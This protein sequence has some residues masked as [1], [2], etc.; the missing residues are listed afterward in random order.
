MT[1][2]TP[3]VLVFSLLTTLTFATAMV[4]F[5]NGYGEK[6]VLS[7]G[8]KYY[9]FHKPNLDSFGPSSRYSKSSTCRI[10]RGKPGNPGATELTVIK[11]SRGVVVTL[12]PSPTSYTGTG[13]VTGQV[14][15]IALSYR[16]ITIGD[17]HGSQRFLPHS[18]LELYLDETT[19]YR[20]VIVRRREEVMS[21]DAHYDVHTIRLGDVEDFDVGFSKDSFSNYESVVLRIKQG[22]RIKNVYSVIGTLSQV[23]DLRLGFAYSSHHDGL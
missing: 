12:M 21:P 16:G 1:L 4:F 17:E 6:Q 2:R 15:G 10:F 13:Y 7:L 18:F 11:V 14:Q 23:E 5:F 20:R 22:T 19:M 9:A 3:L 8:G